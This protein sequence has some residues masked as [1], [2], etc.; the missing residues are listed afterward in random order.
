[1]AH[2]HIV[3]EH[4]LGL[5]AAR[6]IAFAWAE[7]AEADFEMECTYA[8]GKTADTVTFS[9]SG[10]EGEL[11]VTAQRFE[12]SARL[13]LLVGAFKGRIES[14]IE[15]ALDKLLAAKPKAA[16]PATKPVTKTV[17]KTATKTAAARSK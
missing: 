8:E 11:E 1:M 4:Q 9:R 13:G 7:Q 5:A 12:L 16:K 15:T 3:R 2:I 14:E 17:A 10:V 6:K